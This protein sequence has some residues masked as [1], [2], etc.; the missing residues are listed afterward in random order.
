MFSCKAGGR[1]FHTAGPLYAKLRC[2]SS[3][4]IKLSLL[5]HELSVI[6]T[7]VAFVGAVSAVAVSITS[8]SGVNTVSA[9]ALKLP[10]LTSLYAVCTHRRVFVVVVM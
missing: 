10:R 5:S 9:L 3:S 2:Q 8:A 4:I 7:A 1:L 6:I